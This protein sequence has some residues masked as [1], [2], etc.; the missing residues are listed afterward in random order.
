VVIY[1]ISN[2]RWVGEPNTWTVYFANTIQKNPEDSMGG[3][4]P[5]RGPVGVLGDEVPHQKL[6]QNVELVYNF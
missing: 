3:V 5:G 1:P 6:K 4:W 2:P